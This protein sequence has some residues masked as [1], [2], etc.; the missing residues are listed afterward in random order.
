[1]KC[2]V[3]VS[4]KMSNI[5]IAECGQIT[6]QPND[7]LIVKEEIA[8]KILSHYRPKLIEAGICE[9]DNLRNGHYQYE[10]Y[11]KGSLEYFESRRDKSMQNKFYRV[12]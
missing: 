8:K 9:M 7:T 2:R 10:S 4:N 5:P 1:M 3:L 6:L 12:T 11:S